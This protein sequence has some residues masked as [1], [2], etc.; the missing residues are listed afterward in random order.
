VSIITP[1]S[2]ELT[3][4]KVRTALAII[5]DAFPMRKKRAAFA[6]ELRQRPESQ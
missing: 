4:V 6:V 5:M 1:L 2:H 3:G